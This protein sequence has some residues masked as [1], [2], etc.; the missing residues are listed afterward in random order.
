MDD[1]YEKAKQFIHDQNEKEKEKQ[2]HSEHKVFEKPI[3]AD[4][5]NSPFGSTQKFSFE[6]VKRGVALII[7]GIGD[8]PARDGVRETPTRVAKM[9][10]EILNGY[11]EKYMIEEITK[12]FQYDQSGM[13]IVKDIPFYSFCEHHMLPFFGKLHIAYI[14]SKQ[15][16]LG[17]SKLV[18]IARLFAKQLQVQERLTFQIADAISKHVPNK[19]VAVRIEAE[20]LCMS[21]RGVRVPNSK[22]ITTKLTQ[23]FQDDPKTRAEFLEGIK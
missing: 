10:Q 22:T 19:G 13:V 20:H 11:D 4:F 18:R 8:D 12:T 1:S 5:K 14:P 6:L 9:Y 23:L 17:L 15:K 16:I 2:N 7:E 3:P 21:I